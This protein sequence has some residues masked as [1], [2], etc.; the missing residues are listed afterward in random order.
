MCEDYLLRVHK[1]LVIP[2]NFT[3]GN[4][5]ENSTPSE[6][7]MSTMHS[8]CS[9]PAEYQK[10]MIVHLRYV[11]LAGQFFQLTL[12]IGFA[13]VNTMTPA[14]IVGSHHNIHRVSDMRNPKRTVY[15]LQ[16]FCKTKFFTTVP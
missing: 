1:A 2:C 8:R 13:L 4:T 10:E 12:G 16:M 11:R 5:L 9:E 3:S 15:W 7:S 14:L 6:R